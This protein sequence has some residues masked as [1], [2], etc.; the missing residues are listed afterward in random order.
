MSYQVF[1][2]NWWK[3]DSTGQLVSDP[4]A[5]LHPYARVDT[6][7]EARQIC[8]DGN[9]SRPKSWKRLS[10]KFEFTEI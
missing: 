7:A 3:L 2:R 10:R 1:S 4:T 9:A 8:E 5:K 6:Y